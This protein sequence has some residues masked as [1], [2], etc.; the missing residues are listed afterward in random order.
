MAKQSFS[1]V[2]FGLASIIPWSLV[3]VLGTLLVSERSQ[4][5]F[6]PDKVDTSVDNGEPDS[7][8][9][10]KEKTVAK[11][12]NNVH[13]EFVNIQDEGD[14]ALIYKLFSGSSEYLKHSVSLSDTSQFDSILGRVQTS[15]GWNRESYP[16]FTQAVSDY[17]AA[18]GYDTPRKLDTKESREWFQSIFEALA[19]ATR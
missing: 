1:E 13:E 4:T 3:L 10:I 7:E 18:A 8:E 2:K 16:E 12:L 19:E 5:L 17:L 9:E 11:L 15:Y 14:R 6:G